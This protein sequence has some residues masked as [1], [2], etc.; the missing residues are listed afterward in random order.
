MEK[1]YKLKSKAVSENI[2]YKH[3]HHVR[4]ELKYYECNLQQQKKIGDKACLCDLLI[5]GSL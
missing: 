4:C 1:K 5:V 2:I 3:G